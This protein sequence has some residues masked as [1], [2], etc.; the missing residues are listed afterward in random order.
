M[1]GLS[2]DSRRP[3]RHRARHG[4]RSR[5]RGGAGPRPR[6][7]A[8]G[9][10]DGGE[11]LAA[12][13]QLLERI[14]RESAES[15][16]DDPVRSGPGLPFAATL[17]SSNDLRLP[18]ESGLRPRSAAP[19]SYE[20]T[21]PQAGTSDPFLSAPATTRMPSS[22]VLPLQPFSMGDT[23]GP[24]TPETPG[25]AQAPADPAGKGEPFSP[26]DADLRPPSDPRPPSDGIGA[27][28]APSDPLA[29]GSGQPARVHRIPVHIEPQ[30]EQISLRERLETPLKVVAAGVL[31]S[32]ADPLAR[33]FLTGV[34]VRLLWVAEILVVVGVLWAI[35]RLV[36]P[37]RSSRD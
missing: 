1:K 3:L 15:G 14:E 28:R 29:D 13:R 25:P 30:E 20:A 23:P 19:T 31:L 33:P 2:R 36:L 12:R 16:A 6:G 7:R 27:S 9:R 10:G 21:L 22:P 4:D 5:V 37:L 24:G 26:L 34:P 17:D 18:V 32:V 11:T 35:G 8:L